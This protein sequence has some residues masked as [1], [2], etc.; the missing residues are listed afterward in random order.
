[1]GNVKALDCCTFR[2]QRNK[3]VIYLTMS[4]LKLKSNMQETLD[5][6]GYDVLGFKSVDISVVKYDKETHQEIWDDFVYKTANGNLFQTRKFLNYHPADKFTEHS[7]LFYEGEHLVAIA[8]GEESE[9]AWSSHKFTS[10]AGL[11]VLSSLSA[12]QIL[13]IVWS[14]IEYAGKNNWKHLKMRYAPDLLS[15]DEIQLVYWAL[16]VFKFQVTKQELT[17]VMLPKDSD[18]LLPKYHSSARRSVKKAIEQ[19]LSFRKSDDFS[20]FWKLLE[21][22]LKDKYETNPTH[23]LEEINYLRE[24]CKDSI[25]LYAVFNQE[26]KM[27][28]GSVVFD[29][30]P[31]VSHTFYFAQD[32]NYQ[33]LRS[34]PFL[35]YNLDKEYTVNRKRLLNLGVV[36]AN[37]GQQ[38]NMGLSNFKSHFSTIPSIRKTYELDLVGE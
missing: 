28:A 2:W 36:V 33:D 4:S 27:L 15:K 7:L 20:A 17:W 14:L 21:L 24:L 5:S 26:D 13:S 23:S 3:L 38:I 30:A 10:H 22:N 9:D 8:A 19:G 11:S 29:I 12:D 1:M 34:M 18:D 35:M 6:F 32:Y 31:N 25:E 37:G 16:S